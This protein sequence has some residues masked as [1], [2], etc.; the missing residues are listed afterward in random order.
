MLD[1]VRRAQEGI[2]FRAVGDPVGF[3]F[4]DEEQH[5][6]AALLVMNVTL[7][8]RRIRGSCALALP[9][10][11]SFVD[12]IIVVHGGR[13]I[14]L[15]GLVQRDKEHIQFLFR[16]PL[17]TLADGGWL[18]EIQRHQ[19]LVAGIGAV[20]VQGAIEAQIHRRVDEIDMVILILQ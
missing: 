7:A 15:V 4:P 2:G 6:A 20:Q 8:G 18:Q 10:E 16:Q 12:G 14:I 13:R 17:H 5:A 3:E 1:I 19:K 9:V 11:Q